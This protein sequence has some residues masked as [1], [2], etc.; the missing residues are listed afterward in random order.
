MKLQAR[1]PGDQFWLNITAA[2]R[3]SFERC[4]YEVREVRV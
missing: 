4:G 2:Y 1:L 3:A